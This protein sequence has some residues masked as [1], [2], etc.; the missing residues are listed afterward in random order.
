MLGIQTIVLAIGDG[1]NM[2]ELR[3]LA[4]HPYSWNLFTIDS[5]TGL[6]G[7]LGDVINAHYNG[8]G[9]YWYCFICSVESKCQI[10]LFFHLSIII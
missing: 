5:W 10:M 4:S 8:K 3:G 2:M 7:I 9:S 1:M 6:G